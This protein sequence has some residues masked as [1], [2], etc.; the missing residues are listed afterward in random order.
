MV[1]DF[2]QTP[3]AVGMTFI[4]LSLSKIDISVECER[5]FIKMKNFADL[6]SSRFQMCLPY[7]CLFNDAF[8]WRRFGVH[9]RTWVGYGRL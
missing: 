3:F 9:L 4:S 1:C 2:V 8:L 7:V 5:L 6:S